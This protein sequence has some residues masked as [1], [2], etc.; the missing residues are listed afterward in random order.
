MTPISQFDQMKIERDV[1][2]PMR[3]G[4]RLFANLFR[5]TTE[6]P[7]PVAMSV[8]SYDCRFHLIVRASVARFRQGRKRSVTQPAVSEHFAAQEMSVWHD[9]GLSA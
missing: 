4:V 1:A 2:V 7:H 5:P 6:A 8:T 9:E 3:D